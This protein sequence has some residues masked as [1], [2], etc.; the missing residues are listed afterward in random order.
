MKAILS[1]LSNKSII[2]FAYANFKKLLDKSVNQTT[3]LYKFLLKLLV[4]LKTAGFIFTDDNQDNSTQLQ[5][6][7][8][9]YTVDIAVMSLM[10]ALENKTQQEKVRILKEL[11]RA[12]N[13]ELA[14]NSNIAISV[15]SNWQQSSN[16]F[17]K[18]ITD[19]TK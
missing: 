18:E 10:A 13:A 14:N 9:T 6:V 1:L 8:E 17:T 11:E 15:V 19:T 2:D 7:M 4:G 5:I 12:I 3:Y 16:Y